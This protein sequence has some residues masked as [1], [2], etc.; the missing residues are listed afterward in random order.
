MRRRG[1]GA[2][3]QDPVYDVYGVR[4]VARRS[5]REGVQKASEGG[6]RVLEGCQALDNARPRERWIGL[7]AHAVS[8]RTAS[9]RHRRREVQRR[10]G[11][12]QR[13]QE[14]QEDRRGCSTRTT[15]EG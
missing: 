2:S 6:R 5:I 9:H 1:N 12:Q 7:V 14:E 11:R 10:A 13:L 3:G 8:G 4:L 15:M